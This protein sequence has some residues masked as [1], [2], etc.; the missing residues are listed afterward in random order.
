[1]GHGAN[2]RVVVPTELQA[3]VSAPLGVVHIARLIAIAGEHA[4]HRGA[5]IA[6]LIDAN[7]AGYLPL[8]VHTH[9][10]GR[11]VGVFRLLPFA[12][13]ALCGRSQ[14]AFLTPPVRRPFFVRRGFL[15]FRKQRPLALLP[16]LM[17]SALY[18]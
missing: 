13:E 11:F 6:V 14:Q 3:A 10:G 4:L 16:R 1:M 15:F 17:T 2:G 7:G 5:A 12:G 8:Y 9:I 18:V